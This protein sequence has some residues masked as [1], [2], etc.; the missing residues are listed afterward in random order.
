MKITSRARNICIYIFFIAIVLALGLRLFSYLA[1]P[2]KILKESVIL[3]QR[4][5]S[6]PIKWADGRILNVVSKRGLQTSQ[7]EAIEIWSQDS[8]LISRIF[9]KLGLISALTVKN[10]LYIFGATDWSKS[11]EVQLLYTDDLINFSTP[12]IVLR[13][14]EKQTIFNTSVT[15]GRNGHYFMAY[16]ICD[17]SVKCFSIRFA[18]SRNLLTWVPLK[19]AYRTDLY[20]ACPT[21][22]YVND[23]FYLFYLKVIGKHGKL[24]YV[25]RVA[26]SHNLSN[27]EDSSSNVLEPAS[28]GSDGVNTSDMDL[29]EDSGSVV[30]NFAIGHQDPQV[31]NWVKIKQCIYQTDLEKYVESF[32]GIFQCRRR[33]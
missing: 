7:G 21:L 20:T 29:V 25:T 33:S 24:K 22:R 16:E 18:E 1:H 31:G 30:V 28:D 32:F 10:R 19:L 2:I 6:T 27:W 14:A 11:N 23:Y 15:M 17:P 8:K 26:R 4:M 5:E 3:N 9:S 12:K 13:A